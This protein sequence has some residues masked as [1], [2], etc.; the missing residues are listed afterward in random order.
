MSKILLISLAMLAFAAN[1]VLCRMALGE[2]VIDAASFTTIRLLSGAI[3]LAVIL[4]FN[5]SI[6]ERG[7]VS[8]D[9]L[10][11]LM[12]FLYAIFFSFAYIEL[13]TGTGALI[14]FGVVQITM[15]IAGVL[16]GERLKAAAWFG[17]LM[18][19]SGLVYL[20]L[21]GV[22]APSIT[23]ALF[24]MLSG[25]AWGI[26]SLRGKGVVKPVIATAKNFIGTVPLV[27]I[28]SAIF[29]QSIQLS[30]SGLILAVMSGAIASALGYVLWY[31]VLPS[32]TPSRAAT[33]QLSVPVIATL[34]GVLLMDELFT[35]RLLIAGVAVLGG[36]VI[37]IMVKNRAEN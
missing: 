21:P 3:T 12:L 27:L 14:L 23:G 11:S 33:V 9:P 19:F 26:Y 6:V 10:S 18:A 7:G 25:F 2:A 4:L 36:I 15:V 5:S 28:S 34:G 35:S 24:M 17:M 13:S 29:W 37:T 16:Q 32:I 22:T 30:T 8:F 1:S 20:M 31:T